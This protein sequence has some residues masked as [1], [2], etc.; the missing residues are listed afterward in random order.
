[1]DLDECNKEY[2]EDTSPEK[3][4]LR[5]IVEKLKEE[6]TE[7]RSCLKFL[8]AHIL[9]L[10]SQNSH[11]KETLEEYTSSKDRGSD[12]ASKNTKWVDEINLKSALHDAPS[13]QIKLEIEE[14]LAS[15]E[16]TVTNLCSEVLLRNLNIKR[17]INFWEKLHLGEEFIKDNPNALDISDNKGFG[18]SIRNIFKC[19]PMCPEPNCGAQ[20][21]TKLGIDGESIS[22]ELNNITD[23][24]KAH[25]AVSPKK[26]FGSS[27]TLR[28][29]KRKKKR[30]LVMKQKK[31]KAVSGSRK[32]KRVDFT[33]SDRKRVD[34]T[35]SKCGL[36][37]TYISLVKPSRVQHNCKGLTER[38]TTNIIGK[39]HR[40]TGGLVAL[41]SFTKKEMEVKLREGEKLL[42]RA[43]RK[44]WKQN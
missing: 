35:C 22:L 8:K 42:L 31:K 39:V 24:E 11:L 41:G 37:K 9:S 23:N 7:L 1:M 25:S 15:M 36:F 10:M 2:S 4:R 33:C 29:S 30:R 26:E 18:P 20:F 3:R 14:N 21:Q 28:K 12:R 19:N 27:I 40:R 13:K 6:N 34:F 38:K 43:T 5:E 16:Q 44:V 17:A 32:R